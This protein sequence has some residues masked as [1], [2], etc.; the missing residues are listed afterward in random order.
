[1]KEGRSSPRDQ[2]RHWTAIRGRTPEIVASASGPRVGRFPEGC[3]IYSTVSVP[4]CLGAIYWALWTGCSS[5]NSE[6]APS[7][8]ST[9]KSTTSGAPFASR[10]IPMMRLLGEEAWRPFHEWRRKEDRIHY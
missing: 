3:E 8:F 1:M 2:P 4:H 10:R 6:D 7:G 5:A 9:Q